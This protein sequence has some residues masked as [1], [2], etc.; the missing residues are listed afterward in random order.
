MTE[1][2]WG[3][4]RPGA[5]RKPLSAK[6]KRARDAKRKAQKIPA[7]PRDPIDPR[8][9]AAARAGES[10]RQLANMAQL[11]KDGKKGRAPELNPFRL[12]A[13]PP[14][15]I[16]KDK[17]L[18]LAMD[19]S[20]NWAAQ[21]WAQPGGIAAVAAAEGLVFLGYPYLCEL[22]QRPEYRV[23]SETIAD[24]STRKWID[25]EVTG[26]PEAEDD[27]QK[28][29]QEENEA[30]ARGRPVDPEE[31]R[32]RRAERIKKY[33]KEDKIKRIKDDQERLNLRGN[34]YD[35]S[36]DDGFFGRSHLFLDFGDGALDAD[37]ITELT[38]TI[39]DGRDAISRAKVSPQKPLRR[40]KKVEPIW[41]YP[42]TYNAVNPLLDDWYNPQVWFVLG[43]QIHCTRLITFIGHPVPDF[44][45]PVYAFGGLSLSQ[46]AKPYVDIWLQTRQSVAQ[47]VHA[48]S[49]MV[50]KT[51]MQQVLQGSGSGDSLMSRVGL[52]N[53]WRDNLGLFVLNNNT[54]DFMNV[55]ASL[56][57]LHE[58][59]AQSQE[60][61]MSVVRIPATKFTG[62]QPSGLSTTSEGEMRAY[63]DT[64]AAYQNRFY[65]PGLQRI[66][67][68]EQLSLFGDIDPEI[69][70]V[71]E[72]LWEMSEK[73][74]AE[75][76]KIEAERDNILVDMGAIS[77][78]E[79]RVQVINDPHM[80]YGDLDPDELPDLRE[81]EE[82]GLVPEGAGRAVSGLL[83]SGPGAGEGEAPAEQGSGAGEKPGKAPGAGA[84]DQVADDEEDEPDDGRLPYARHYAWMAGYDLPA[85]RKDGSIVVQQPGGEAAAMGLRIGSRVRYQRTG[86]EPARGRVFGFVR[87]AGGVATLDS[88]AILNEET[89]RAVF[90]PAKFVQRRPVEHDDDSQPAEGAK[91]SIAPFQVIAD[92]IGGV[93][94]SLTGSAPRPIETETP[95]ERRLETI[96]SG[97]Q[98]EG[99]PPQREHSKPPVSA[100]KELDNGAASDGSAPTVP[101]PG[102]PQESIARGE[103]PM[104][105]PMSEAE[106]RRQLTGDAEGEFDE[107]KHPRRPDG[108]FGTG[109]GTSAEG[110]SEA[111]GEQNENTENFKEM[112]HAEAKKYATDLVK[113]VEK[114]DDEE[115]AAIM[116][117]QED[118]G[119]KMNANLHTGKELTPD[120]QQMMHTLDKIAERTKLPEGLVLHR[121]GTADFTKK[122]E[123]LKPGDVVPPNLG[124]M[125]TSINNIGEA[126][127]FQILTPAG[128]NAI[129]PPE[130]F[131]GVAEIILSRNTSL[132]YVGKNDKGEHQMKIAGAPTSKAEAARASEAESEKADIDDGTLA[133]PTFKSKKEHAAHLLKK[134]VTTKEMLAAL[135]WPSISMPAM[136]KS[137]NMRLEKT[138]EG[139]V[140]RYVGIPL[141]SPAAK[142]EK[143]HSLLGFIGARGG[144]RS[145]DGNIE[146]VRTSI[147]RKNKFVPGYGQLI[148]KPSQLSTAAQK[149][150]KYAAMRIDQA[151]EAAIEAGYLSEGASLAD[152][153][154]QVDRELRGEKVYPQN[155]VPENVPED[156][157]EREHAEAGFMRDLDDAIAEGGGTDLS[158][159]ERKRALEL[160]Q[161]EGVS[162]PVDVLERLAMESDDDETESGGA[163][164]R[165]EP[166]TGWDPDPNIGG[167]DDDVF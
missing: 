28:Q 42:T 153:L 129:V 94:P 15:A 121:Y 46:M 157:G 138:K 160:W 132:E 74:R 44:L 154:E 165:A 21:D 72:S 67:N 16:P 60:H 50:F 62:I 78:A 66:I 125:S 27:K 119:M 14:A 52:F 102:V 55:S 137:L 38:S 75:L 105:D 150:G 93:G 96:R 4:A 77:P 143:T 99:P 81:E 53:S 142:P 113:K 89:D 25:W 3:G 155:Y 33:G 13:F 118:V 41:T 23:M 95:N 145:D 71:F 37:G 76:Q 159:K 167:D 90:V 112:D 29:Q 122:L 79:K 56:S 115:Y 98:L 32:A 152:F 34:M 1:G 59:Q 149:S 103:A 24:D 161:R 101:N 128:T 40:I 47:L 54:E 116:D 127:T 120:Q 156:P 123:T 57:G 148:R 26:I 64:I 151:R 7:S 114:L 12:P 140:T 147:G 108:K 19:S 82:G 164:A 36:R 107:S 48:F 158:D 17:K 100:W 61:M 144:L 110:E 63:Y 31:S 92:A 146:D 5:G 135:S 117:Y 86:E 8:L 88:V 30:A 139:G 163:P 43:K 39:G 73:E 106:Q 11:L 131:E 68:F 124:F 18:Q 136:A 166:V 87:G 91:D 69:D 10:M 65:R 2:K 162:D 20:L 22:A 9:V 84:G 45:K 111:E 83:E 49:V 126:G 51:D 97:T 70:F 58:L 130:I 80:P 133:T 6:E 104:P 85:K 109:T 134:G 35:V 141:N